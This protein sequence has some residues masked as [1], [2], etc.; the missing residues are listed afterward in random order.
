MKSEGHTDVG[1]QLDMKR[2]DDG[3]EIQAAAMLV[4]SLLRIITSGNVPAEVHV[5]QSRLEQLKSMTLSDK[6]NRLVPPGDHNERN[7]TL[8]A[9]WWDENRDNLHFVSR[10]GMLYPYVVSAAEQAE[11][12]VF[13]TVFQMLQTKGLEKALLQMGLDLQT[14]MRSPK[15]LQD[16][17]WFQFQLMLHERM[18]SII[19]TPQDVPIFKA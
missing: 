17:V 19:I 13:A 12:T 14:L 8:V 15:L 6:V 5:D 11:A 10:E 4:N 7:V 1:A 16:T 2:S 18:K 9:A 3:W